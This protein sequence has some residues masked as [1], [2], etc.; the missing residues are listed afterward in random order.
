MA[1]PTN[2][3][4]NKLADLDAQIADIDETLSTGVSMSMEDNHQT[5]LDHDTMRAERQTLEAKRDAL[6]RTIAGRRKPSSLNGR[7]SKLRMD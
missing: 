4:Q 2:A 7:F 6:K 5:M 1:T 3:Q